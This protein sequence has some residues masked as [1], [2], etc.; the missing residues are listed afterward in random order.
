MIERKSFYFGR[1]KLSQERERKSKQNKRRKEGGDWRA[2]T[3]KRRM[4]SKA[5]K[6]FLAARIREE[7]I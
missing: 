5:E 7:K 6:A 4:E 2:A 3:L 1:E